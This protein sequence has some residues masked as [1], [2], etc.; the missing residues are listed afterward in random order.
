VPRTKANVEFF[1]LANNQYKSSTLPLA[2]V[3]LLVCDGCGAVLDYLI[4]PYTTCELRQLRILLPTIQTGS[5]V[6]LDRGFSAYIVLWSLDASGSFF[7]ARQHQSRSGKKIRK[8]GKDDA[9][10]EWERPKGASEGWADVRLGCDENMVIRVLTVKLHIRGHR[11]RDVVLCTNLLDAEKYPA[12]ELMDL[13]LERWNIELDIRTLKTQHHL[14]RLSAKSPEIIRKEI[15]SILMAFNAVRLI[16]VE[17]ESTFRKLSHKRACRLLLEKCSEMV[18]AATTL[19]LALYRHMLQLI[20]TACLRRNK[21]CSQPRAVIFR[22]RDWPVLQI[23]RAAWQRT[24][25]IAS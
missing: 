2:R 15:D 5:L 18:C 7:L 4:D 3:L 17:A 14:D 16:M 21:R 19:L 20:R 23:S 6:L 13:Y 12:Q 1:G 22:K 9:L 10:Y 11:D 25:K 24:G 8:L